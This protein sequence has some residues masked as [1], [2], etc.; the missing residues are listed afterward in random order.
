MVL[1]TRRDLIPGY[2]AVQPAHALAEFQAKHPRIFRNWQTN[3][4]NLAILAVRNEKELLAIIEKAGELRI[5]HAPFKE[6]DI[7]N[8]TTAV[9]LEPCESTYRLVSQLP[10]ALKEYN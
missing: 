5:K 3:H 9:A 1:V 10:L 7:G 8:E 6:P 2:Q 4:K